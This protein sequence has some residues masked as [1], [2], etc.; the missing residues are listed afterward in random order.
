[1]VMGQPFSIRLSEPAEQMLQEEA[2]RTARS[3]S[4]VVAAFADEGL[5]AQRFPGLAFRGEHPRRRAWVIGSGLDIW[6][7]I[8]MFQDYGSADRLVAETHLTATQLRIAIAYHSAF[9]DEVDTAIAE[10]RR[11]P[12]ELAALH[13]FVV[14]SGE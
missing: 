12:K 5:R 10:N 8:Q 2:R 9:P 4:A 6:E 1:M 14:P 3:K 11:D 7:V 13:P